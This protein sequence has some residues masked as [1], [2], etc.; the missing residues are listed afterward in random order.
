MIPTKDMVVR[1]GV[2]KLLFQSRNREAYDSNL[3]GLYGSA[4]ALIEFQSRNREAYDSN[5]LLPRLVV[6]IICNCYRFNLVIEKLM[7][8]TGSHDPDRYGF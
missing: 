1:W 4:S 7:I 3:D 2:K 5:L 6:M 8:L